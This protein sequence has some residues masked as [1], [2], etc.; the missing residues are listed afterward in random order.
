MRLIIIVVRTHCIPYVASVTEVVLTYGSV[1][2][3]VG[4][5]VEYEVVAAI[6]GDEV[7]STAVYVKNNNKP[8]IT[9][10]SRSF[11]L[12]I[13]ITLFKYYLTNLDIIYMYIY[14]YIYIAFCLNEHISVILRILVT[15]KKIE[16]CKESLL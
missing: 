5:M 4:I 1:G 16:V 13:F 12:N 8:L 10:Y 2:R 11:T 3:D 6:I 14:I 15:V 7:I 9:A